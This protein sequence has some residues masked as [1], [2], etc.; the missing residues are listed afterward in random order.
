MSGEGWVKV[1]ELRR[2]S[3]KDFSAIFEDDFV[4]R[5]SFVVHSSFIRRSFVV[6]R[7]S[8]VRRRR[9][10]VVGGGDGDDDDV[11]SLKVANTISGHR[12]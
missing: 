6:R 10:V 8:F 7:S 9:N 4:R 1:N 3:M 2:T 5:S 12:S 11:V